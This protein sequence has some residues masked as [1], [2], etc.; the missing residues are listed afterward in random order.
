M[1]VG[2]QLKVGQAT[3]ERCLAEV[4]IEHAV[5]AHIVLQAYVRQVI[6]LGYEVDVLQHVGLAQ[7]AGFAVEGNCSLALAQQSAHKVEQGRLAR[8]VLAQQSVD[9][10][11]AR[12][13]EK[14]LKT[15][16]L[17]PG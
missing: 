17:L 8:A 10:A 9:A 11:G 16:C 13:S 14:S 12:L 6:L 1:N 7:G 5:G 4:G 2:R 3:V 15:K